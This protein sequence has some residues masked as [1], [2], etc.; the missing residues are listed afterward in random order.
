MT[1]GLILLGFIAVVFALVMAR[2]RRRLGMGVTG[3]IRATTVAGFAIV[4]L[5]LWA[6]TRK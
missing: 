6:T 1:N 2:F 5:V 4:V 3:R